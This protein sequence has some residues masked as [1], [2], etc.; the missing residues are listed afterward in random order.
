LNPGPNREE[1]IKSKRVSRSACESGAAYRHGEA[2][3]WA[4]HWGTMLVSTLRRLSP[5]RVLPARCK[6]CRPVSP[7]TL[8]PSLFGR[9][10]QSE[11]QLCSPMASFLYSLALFPVLTIT[12]PATPAA[13]LAGQPW[14][15]VCWSSPVSA[16][17]VLTVGHPLEKTA[18]LLVRDCH[19]ALD[20]IDEVNIW[21]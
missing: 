8:L 4:Q 20:G 21:L 2:L 6:L 10:A 19:F 17:M 16:S 13:H 15:A 3:A 14:R 12:L 7:P 5:L 9:T 1:S 11:K 18:L